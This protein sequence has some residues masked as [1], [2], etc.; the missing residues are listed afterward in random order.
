[1]NTRAAVTN[2]WALLAGMAFIMTG[3][4]LQ[5]TLLGVR[6]SIEGFSTESTGLIMTGYF[7]GFLGGS[8]IVPRLVD[9]V[10]H[11]RT[12]AALA[13]IASAAV[14]AHVVF[15]NVSSWTAMR[16][17]TGFAYAGLYLVAES[18]LNDAATNE[19]RGQLLSVYMIIVMGGM[20]AGQ[21]LLNVAAPEGVELFILVS[22][23]VSLS[24]VPITL[25]VGRAPDFDAPEYLS[26]A[27]LYR[28]S[29]LGIVGAIL[30]GLTQAAMF[31]MGAVYGRQAGLSIEEISLFMASLSLGG[32]ALQWPIGWLS[33]RLDRRQVII[34]TCLFG[35]ISAYVAARV[36]NDFPALL[37]SAF[38]LGGATVP[39]YSLFI[40]H[41][42]DHLEPRQ[43]VA[44]SAGL[45]FAGGIGLS[46]GPLLIGLL[47]GRFGTDA[48]FW[49]I[50]STLALAGAFGLWRMTRREA[51][52]M[53]D[54]N[55]YTPT[56]RTS[57]MAAALAAE[58]MIEQHELE[59]DT[60]EKP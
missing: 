42:N 31:G 24:L 53:D 46:G 33:D 48:Y 40:A 57:T 59:P 2:A 11:I 29:P 4:G 19:T 22:V 26:V 28:I 50:G 51:P 15:V 44:A 10:G 43:M 18:W 58:E 8:V 55:A 52:A 39:L 34:G 35:A 3:N 12:F 37:A 54:Q 25:S 49:A 1:M 47:M 41:T 21:L 45:V 5:G 9:R 14:L 16:L 7:A 20:T 13:S 23:L 56:P 27:K 6:A 32:I 30:T 36:A 38:A 60:G 17:A